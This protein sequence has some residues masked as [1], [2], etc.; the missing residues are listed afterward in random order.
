MESTAGEQNEARQPESGA[1]PIATRDSRGSA[2]G[3]TDAIPSQGRLDEAWI[4]TTQRVK[5]PQPLW[6]EMPTHWFNVVEATFALNRI[7]SDETKYRHIISN[8][9]PTIIPFVTDLITDPPNQNKYVAIKKRII[10]AFGESKEAKLRK[11]LRGQEL[12]DDKP[13]H[14]LQRL[15]NLAGSEGSDSVI[16]TLF[17]EQL[18]ES[19]R[20][21]LAISPEDDLDTLAMQT[22]K[23]ME[24][25]SISSIRSQA[26][27][28]Y[29]PSWRPPTGDKQY[30]TGDTSANQRDQK[31]GGKAFSQVQ[32]RPIMEQRQS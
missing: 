12:G 13:S 10:G 28:S 14:L 11:L 18:P 4:N 9:D 22:N 27:I 21:I 6:R 19:A 1:R 2:S 31:Y 24:V 7:S 32:A 3:T 16:R 15:R 25:S 8:L 26:A 30:S 20:G 5:L 23:I 29:N 17:L